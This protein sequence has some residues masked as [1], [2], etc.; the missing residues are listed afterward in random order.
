MLRK[1]VYICFNLPY[2]YIYFQT[3]N[4]YLLAS[5][6]QTFKYYVGVGVVGFVIVVVRRH[7]DD[8]VSLSVRISMKLNQKIQYHTRTL[9]MFFRWWFQLR[10][11]EW[12]KTGQKLD[13]TVY[14]TKKWNLQVNIHYIIKPISTPLTTII[15]CQKSIMY[16]MFNNSSSSDLSQ[17]WITGSFLP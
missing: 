14:G 8:N 9:G 11:N 13:N 7:S 15:L 1:A 10:Q 4:L 5:Q 12:S 6:H 3:M 16:Q 2:N 17:A